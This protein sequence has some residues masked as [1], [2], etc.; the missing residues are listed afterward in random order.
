MK[1]PLLKLSCPKTFSFKGSISSPANSCAQEGP[2]VSS[3]RAGQ[4]N[5][6]PTFSWLR[7]ALETR[8]AGDDKRTLLNITSSELLTSSPLTG[9]E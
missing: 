8:D 7:I 3:R 4:G 5:P 1:G 6:N 2:T 9:E